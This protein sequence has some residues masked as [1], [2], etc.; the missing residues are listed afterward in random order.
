MQYMRNYE[1][2]QSSRVCMPGLSWKIETVQNGGV[3]IRENT[4]DDF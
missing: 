3:L 2:Y 1:V 4:A